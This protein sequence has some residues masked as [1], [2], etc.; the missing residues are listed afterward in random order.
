MN[1]SV[2]VCVCV[3]VYACVCLVPI[4]ERRGLDTAIW[5]RGKRPRQPKQDARQTL[6]AKGGA[7]AEVNT[8]ICLEFRF[9]IRT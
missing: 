3:Y 6:K 7:A 8:Q 5:H 4:G 1:V 2:C 9:V